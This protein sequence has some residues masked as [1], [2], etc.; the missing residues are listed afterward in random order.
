M[1]R[2]RCNTGILLTCH[3]LDLGSASDWSKKFSLAP[4]PI[5]NTTQ[6]WV[7]HVISMEFLQ[8]F[9]RRHFATKP[10]MA[11]RN[12]GCFLR[13]H[14]WALLQHGDKRE[15]VG[16]WNLLVKTIWCWRVHLVSRIKHPE[17]KY[18]DQPKWRILHQ[19]LPNTNSPIADIEGHHESK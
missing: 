14:T 3:Y 18:M 4:R 10:V 9:L 2:N 12:A 6:I 11:L 8:S 7:I 13:L 16:F 1:V 19:A 15:I 17:N 5:G